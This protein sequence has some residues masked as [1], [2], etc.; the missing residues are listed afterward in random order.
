MLDSYS[1]IEFASRASNL[2]ERT[3]IVK[4]LAGHDLQVECINQIN[5]LDTWIVNKLAGKLAIKFIKKNTNQNQQEFELATKTAEIKQILSNYKLYELNLANLPELY[6]WEF[7][8]THSKWL[9]TYQ[10]ALAT[11]DLQ[12]KN[13]RY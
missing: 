6:R 13:F 11:L 5:P 4:E 3:S 2:S 10:A 8:K 7:I 1:L 9:D 12:I